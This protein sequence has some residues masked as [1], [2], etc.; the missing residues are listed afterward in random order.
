MINHILLLASLL[1][2]HNFSTAFLKEMQHYLCN[3][4]QGPKVNRSLSNWI[5]LLARVPEGKV[6]FFIF[7]FLMDI[8]YR[9]QWNIKL[10]SPGALS[11]QEAPG[12]K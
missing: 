7:H 2:A 12:Y 11:I 10:Q 4:L 5:K 9:N 6:L 8:V 1:E 3:T